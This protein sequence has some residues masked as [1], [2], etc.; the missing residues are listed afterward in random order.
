VLRKWGDPGHVIGAAR[1][2]FLRRTRKVGRQKY[3]LNPVGPRR[4]Q[5]GPLGPGE[6]DRETGSRNWIERRALRFREDPAVGR[7]QEHL[8]YPVGPL[9]GQEDPR[10]PGEVDQGAG[11]L[12][13]TGS[14]TDYGF[15]TQ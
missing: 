2:L 9:Q 11:A 8:L 15:M 5:E 1:E 14:L 3:P 12:R 6:V 13:E 7:G 4:G 10:G